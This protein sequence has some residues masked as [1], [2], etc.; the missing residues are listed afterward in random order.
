MIYTLF[1][2]TLVATASSSTGLSQKFY[3]WRPIAE[4]HW[5]NGESSNSTLYKCQD[6]AKQLGYTTERYRCLRTK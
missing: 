4:V 1:V 3:D 2:W 5:N 6:V